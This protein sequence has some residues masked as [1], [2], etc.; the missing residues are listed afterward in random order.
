MQLDSR[1]MQTPVSVRS[2]SPQSQPGAPRQVFTSPR[3]ERAAEENSRL[4]NVVALEP[5]WAAAIDAATD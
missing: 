5:H 3:G 2:P 1:T 4:V